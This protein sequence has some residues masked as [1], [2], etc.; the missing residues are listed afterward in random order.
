MRIRMRVWKWKWVW[1]RMRISR[2]REGGGGADGDGQSDAC[3]P[4]GHRTC[5]MMERG[6]AG[7]G[8]KEGWHREMDVDFR[9]D[10]GA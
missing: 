2:A 5:D 8:E 4:F 7:C 3:Q 1:M 9:P 6:C 10:D